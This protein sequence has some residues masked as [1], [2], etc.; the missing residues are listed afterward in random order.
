MAS[1]ARE[2]GRESVITVAAIQTRART[3][4]K[5]ANNVAALDALHRAADE[6]ARLMVLPRARQLGLRPPLT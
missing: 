6:G 4:A 5:E 1:D 2:P 3:G